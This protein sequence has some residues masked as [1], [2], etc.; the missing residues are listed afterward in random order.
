MW[1]GDLHEN[2][3]VSF[4]NYSFVP[5]VVFFLCLDRKQ[6]NNANECAANRID[7]FNRAGD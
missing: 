7:A 1:L 3:K 4:K 6:M 2:G 5:Q